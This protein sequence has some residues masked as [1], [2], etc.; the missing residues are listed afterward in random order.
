MGLS[1][2]TCIPV[3]YRP[4]NL[5]SAFCA[6]ALGIGADVI[7]VGTGPVVI[8]CVYPTEGILIVILVTWSVAKYK[9]IC[10]LFPLAVVIWV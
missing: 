10:W 2:V 9:T 4:S 5:N 6:P 7:T 1:L 3:L 8:F